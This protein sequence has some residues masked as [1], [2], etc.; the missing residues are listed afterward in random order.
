V[1]WIRVHVWS[2]ETAYPL[3][4]NGG[5]GSGPYV[6]GTKASITAQM[7]P[8]GYAFDK[9][10]IHGDAAVDNPSNPSATITVPTSDVTITATYRLK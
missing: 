4:V 2:E 5:V 10:V 8:V 3:T 9:W 1:D 6:A 7:A